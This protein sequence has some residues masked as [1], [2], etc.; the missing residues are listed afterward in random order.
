MTAGMSEKDMAGRAAME[1]KEGFYVNLGIGMPTLVLDFIPQN[2]TVFFHTENGL[3]GMGG[4][5]KTG[6]AHP[7][8]VDAAKQPVTCIKGASF[9]ASDV[10]FAMMRGGHIDLAIMGAY[11]VSGNG[12]LANWT[13]P[14]MMPSVGG[15]MDIVAGV[16]RIIVMMMHTTKDGKPKIVKSLTYPVTGFKCV[17]MII[18]N[19]CVM[20]VTGKGL[21]LK[22]LAPGVS[23]QDVIANTEAELIIPS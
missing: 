19:L 18:T 6:E 16:K 22:E 17:S 14:G 3:L 21:V 4:F 12:D 13:A 20:D 1:I 9:F 8:L 11:Q 2:K 23:V 5:A 7:D 10:S 15:A